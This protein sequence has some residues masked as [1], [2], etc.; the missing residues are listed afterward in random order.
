MT[1]RIGGVITPLITPFERT[2]KGNLNI[3]EKAAKLLINEQIKYGA[4]TLFVFGYAGG[5]TR[6]LTASQRQIHLRNIV[7]H[8]SGKVPVIAGVSDDNINISA[9]LAGQAEKVGADAIVLLLNHGEATYEKKVEAVVKS[10]NNIPIFLYN[11]P[12][13]GQKNNLTPEELKY[14]IVR[15]PKR[16]TGLKESSGDENIFRSFINLQQ[17]LPAMQK[18]SLFMGEAT[19]I[20]WIIQNQYKF[21]FTLPG[22]VPV[23]CNIPERI[24]LYKSL[25]KGQNPTGIEYLSIPKVIEY[26]VDQEKI[27]QAT[28]DF[29]NATD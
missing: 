25:L 20:H 17:S 29:W 7:K 23:E 28:L 9:D 18:F 22:V 21:G 24:P 11:N 15:Y 2:G 4:G 13:V 27:D 3:V 16:I 10:T 1:H 19:K 8:V 5:C 26:L 6:Q 14:L 12:H